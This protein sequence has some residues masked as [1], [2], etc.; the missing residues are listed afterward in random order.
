MLAV[1]ARDGRSQALEQ[2][3]QARP[4]G[5]GARVNVVQCDQTLRSSAPA[6]VAA[7]RCWQD[8]DVARLTGLPTSAPALRAEMPP[9]MP[10][11][12]VP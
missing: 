9:T 12:A 7:G 4:G 3:V 11:E 5:R 6:L 8:R 10:A 2:A 1:A